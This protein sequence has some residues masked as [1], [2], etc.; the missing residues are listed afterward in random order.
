MADTN[1]T[2]GVTLSDADWFNDLNRLH[3]TILGDPGSLAAMKLTLA[4]GDWAT[5]TP[6]VT[7][8]GGAGNTV[9]VYTTN[10]GRYVRVG[11]VVFVEVYLTG[12]GGAEGAGTGVLNI[13]LPVTSGAN[14]VP[15]GSISCGLASNNATSYQ[16]LG[17]IGA[18]SGTI[19]LSYWLTVSAVTSFT[20]AEQNNATRSI[21][22]FFSYEVD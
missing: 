16:L 13:A 8:V 1:F 12:D 18:G 14:A 22:L 19:S 17:L 15:A 6:T 2:N 21:R 3:Y 20:G 5:F 9:P 4:I 10:T 7:L 11:D